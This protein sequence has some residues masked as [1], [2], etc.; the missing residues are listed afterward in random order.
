MVVIDDA[1]IYRQLQGHIIITEQLISKMSNAV[2]CRYFRYIL[3]IQIAKH[4]IYTITLCC[5]CYMPKY[6]P[7][8]EGIMHD[9]K[10]QH[11]IIVIIT[12]N[13]FGDLK[14]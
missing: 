2:A 8:L 1:C 5:P 7:R 4:K 11:N 14:K 13:V 10:G 3:N 6:V 12:L 9:P